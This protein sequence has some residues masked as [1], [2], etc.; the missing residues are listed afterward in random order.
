MI[1]SPIN[2]DLHS[3]S[4]APNSPIKSPSS[5]LRSMLN[6][7]FREPCQDKAQVISDLA[8]RM[9]KY[10]HAR[11]SKTLFLK[12]K[13]ASPIAFSNN[14]LKALSILI[15]KNPH[16][17]SCKGE[18]ESPVIR[19]ALD[20]LGIDLADLL[21]YTPSGDASEEEQSFFHSIYK[22]I[23][24]KKINTSVYTI[25]QKRDSLL[26][27]YI[28]LPQIEMPKEKALVLH[29]LRAIRISDYATEKLIENLHADPSIK[30]LYLSE[31]I[32]G[33]TPNGFNLEN[34]LPTIIFSTK[35]LNPLME[36]A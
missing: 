29:T 13:I 11:K 17:T 23:L 4:S 19:E 10:L 14:A 22:F 21:S 16:L 27:S 28:E 3:N 31:N 6:H 12:D 5:P 30:R 35:R 32:E 2:T 7:L 9:A 25:Q 36:R 8:I 24:E 20:L 18:F 33:S 1:I 34:C 26:A 15:Q